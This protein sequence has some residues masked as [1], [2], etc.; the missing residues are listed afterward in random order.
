MPIEG[1]ERKRI[2]GR[3]LSFKVSLRSE[4]VHGPCGH[5]K[6]TFEGK[7]KYAS[8]KVILR[9]EYVM[10]LRLPHLRRLKIKTKICFVQGEYASFKVNLVH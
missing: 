10:D 2:L 7:D 3:R 8:V 9:S 6:L 4:Y 5:L 1:S